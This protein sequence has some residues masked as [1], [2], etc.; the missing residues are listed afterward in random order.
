MH[1]SIPLLLVAWLIA[2]TPPDEGIALV[3]LSGEGLNPSTIEILSPEMVAVTDEEGRREVPLENLRSI[4]FTGREASPLVGAALFLAG[5]GVLAG[6]VLSAD[7][8]KIHFGSSLI[9]ETSI[10]LGG[11]R[12]IRITPVSMDTTTFQ[13]Q[14]ERKQRVPMMRVM[15]HQRLPV[16]RVK[17]FNEYQRRR[18]Y[19]A[20]G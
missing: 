9:D 15:M 14:M 12:A 11:V 8:E 20:G 17:A 19:R 2:P 6:E 13:R 16:V 5:G 10:S 3:R 7:G 18:F 4:T 1:P